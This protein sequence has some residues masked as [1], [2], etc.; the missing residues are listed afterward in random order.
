MA[1]EA[2]TEGIGNDFSDGVKSDDDFFVV[3]SHFEVVHDELSGSPRFFVN[4]IEH[5]HDD[6]GRTD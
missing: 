5:S 6:L 4:Q 3:E 1:F 2:S